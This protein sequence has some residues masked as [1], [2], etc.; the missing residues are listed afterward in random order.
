MHE[1]LPEVER[2]F[3]GI[4]EGWARFT[5]APQPPVP[6][7]RTTTAT[8]STAAAVTLTPT[9]A[10]ASPSTQRRCCLYVRTP[11]ARL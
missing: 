4:G 6:P 1:L 11:N 8:T 2:R 5:C 7:P 9:A 10:A 3:R